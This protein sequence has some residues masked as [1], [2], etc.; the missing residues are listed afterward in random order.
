[1][2]E[3]TLDTL[4]LEVESK[5]SGA[6]GELDKLE[7]SLSN[8]SRTLG[9]F[10][11]N[12]FSQISTAMNGLRMATGS[13][14]KQ[15]NGMNFNKVI[16]ST[17]AMDMAIN[18]SVKNITSYFGIKGAS[19]VNE[20][21]KAFRDNV[22]SVLALGRSADDASANFE[23]LMADAESGTNRVA[24]AVKKNISYVDESINAY[25]ELDEY[26]RQTNQ[27]QGKIYIPESVKEE[28]G[29][30]YSSMRSTLGSAFTSNKKEMADAVSFENFVDE[31]NGRLGHLIDTNQGVEHS[32]R[33]VYEILKLVREGGSKAFAQEDMVSTKD[34]AGEVY[35]EYL[36]LEKAE[37]AINANP[38]FA[39]GNETT[40][41]QLLKEKLD[42]VT[43][44]VNKKTE[45]F[46]NEGSAV[47]KIV[48]SEIS[49]LMQLKAGVNRATKELQDSLKNASS[50][51]E[52]ANEM[53][54]KVASANPVE[55][56]TSNTVTASDIEAVD[57]ANKDASE[58]AD[59][60]GN[61]IGK[62]GEDAD[63][64]KQK[65]NELTKALTR[66]SL[67]GGALKSLGN[68]MVALGRS[69]GKFSA[70]LAKVS[71][72]LIPGFNR[73]ILGAK[74]GNDG[75]NFS[76]SKAI[77]N[78]LRYGFGIR[79]LFVLFNK[80]RAAM[81]L[82]FGNL[83]HYSDETNANISTLA[84]CLNQ[85]KNSM[86]TAFDPILSVITPILERLISA[87][88][89]ASNAV[90]HFLA[91][92]TGASSFKVA[93]RVATDYAASLDKNAKSTSNANKEAEKYK[94]T[95]LG[96][97]EINQL[98]DTSDKSGGSGGGAG[99]DGINYGDMF[100]TIEVSNEFSDFA[101]KI[102]QMWR[103]ADFTELGTILGTKLKSGLESIPWSDIQIV[104]QKV[105]KSLAT[106]INGGVEVSGLGTAIGT[107]I[108]NAINT[109][110]L[111]VESFAGN[112]HWDSVGKF[113]KDGI[114][115]ALSTINW[116]EAITT[117]GYIGAGVA[118]AIN[119]VM[120][121]DTLENVGSTV[122]GA[123]NT[124]IEY[125]HTFV[126]NAKWGDWGTA[127]A[128]GLN[129][130]F[131]DFNWEGAGLTLRGAVNGFVTFFSNVAKGTDWKLFGRKVS[132][133]INSVDWA[134]ALSS[135]LSSLA[136]IIWDTLA[137]F[138]E[139]PTGSFIGSLALAFGGARVVG[140]AYTFING[141]Y[142]I[143]TGQASAS[144][145]GSGIKW[146]LSDSTGSAVEA[147]TET[148]KPLTDAAKDAGTAANEMARNFEKS[149]GEAGAA[150]EEVTGKVTTA[151]G[152]VSALKVALTGIGEG[153]V[154]AGIVLL[155]QHM[156]KV[157]DEMRGGN[158]EIYAWSTALDDVN[159]VLY[160]NNQITGEQR[161]NLYLL[162]EQW[163][164]NEIGATEYAKALTDADVSQEEFAA[165]LKIIAEQGDLTEKQLEQ[166]NEV[167]ALLGSTA[168]TTT[169]KIESAGI[170]Q[171][172]AYNR[173][174]D[175]L[176]W[177]GA[178]T[179]NLG[180]VNEKLFPIFDNIV[181]SGGSV[182]SAYLAMKDEM[183]KLGIS[184]EDL[185]DDLGTDLYN[186]LKDVNSESEKVETS[187]G[188]AS[189]GI[190][191]IEGSSLKS[192]IQAKFFEGALRSMGSGAEEAKEKHEDLTDSLDDLNTVVVN[193]APVLNANATSLGENYGV[194]FS[195]G[196]KN[197]GTEVYTAIDSLLNEDVLKATR[198]ILDEHSPSKKS[199]EYGEYY[200]LGLANG[201]VAKKQDARDSIG[202]VATEMLSALKDYDGNFESYGKSWVSEICYGIGEKL[203]DLSTSAYDIVST[204]EGAF[205]DLT[206][207]MYRHGK[208][209][210]TEFCNGLYSVGIKMPHVTF[211]TKVVTSGNSSTTSTSSSVK[212]YAKGGLATGASVVGVGE[213][214]N[215]AILPL[216]NR[217]TMSTIAEAI[218]KNMNGFG[219]S[220]VLADAVA[221]GYTLAM[222]NNSGN[223]PPI[224]VN[225]ELRTED[226][227]ILARAVAKGQQS[228]DYRMN[229]VMG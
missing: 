124:V 68:N 37:K 190:L 77:K 19:A 1:M 17:D 183:D 13:L 39:Q 112:L 225:A 160:N 164:N 106:F 221:Q 220:Q 168:D 130:L 35:K 152:E 155:G 118:S 95:I 52:K 129:K 57:Q 169:S 62:T 136:H 42:E 79:S 18:R 184:T 11:A 170:T 49:S 9:A 194:G 202:T 28:F 108:G 101:D 175:A 180:A 143:I 182:E 224:I 162:T 91:A 196:V 117:A 165:A 229:P 72:S 83:A 55:T 163:E 148:I 100:D 90:A 85:L 159:G 123:L 150:V 218:T 210:M 20:V 38:L 6:D 107:T 204:I 121:V 64:A 217:K 146:L 195:K 4:V 31:L 167:Y 24:Q 69:F 174:K 153:A 139:T 149:T 7:R 189:K 33:Q 187:T 158:G 105:G 5:A 228:L 26:I 3:E 134:G 56:A 116:K 66:L 227:E 188:K 104:A 137:G 197:S 74:K 8:L 147:A 138:V 96:F 86:A 73:G 223:Q 115:G 30:D 84:S 226:N 185:K 200:T 78:V 178:E 144:L 27:S 151:T 89:A 154:L 215:E 75:F 45:A 98:N 166:A 54:Q 186:A 126:S 93:K 114:N 63:D 50:L 176:Y 36:N 135:V 65:I 103:E 122:A 58:S 23:E 198:E 16:S 161:E 21:A 191:G 140:T 99:G 173:I 206:D 119:E 34:V 110:I 46:Q 208:N 120:T 179:D 80:L 133:A 145:I 48:Q 40:Q 109:G 61:S 212:W 47:S 10:N 32:F 211:T 44:A 76:I 70:N 205:N 177:C 71:L 43:E 113:V 87:L 125:A 60:A 41:L 142:K 181:S 128:S 201:V 97:D 29:K 219:D 193:T 51:V 15:I 203:Y 81:V 171:T 82:G 2:A 216:E 12:K 207:D 131:Q 53:S 67:I 199:E 102:K 213:A 214:G 209:A 222:M 127:V 22:D 157:V 156:G 172:D 88:V 192:I 92:L 25:K 94:K 132:E 14:T 141:I 111:T 59:E